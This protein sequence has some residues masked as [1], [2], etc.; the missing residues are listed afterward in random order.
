MSYNENY[1]T[2]NFSTFDEWLDIVMNNVK[3]VYPFA[4]IP[5]DEWVQEY[6]ND[7]KI[8]PLMK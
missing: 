3:A 1:Y 4:R 8:N 7:I 2:H 5:Y 6:K